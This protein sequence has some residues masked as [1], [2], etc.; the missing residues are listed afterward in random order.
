MYMWWGKVLPGV[1]EF[2]R[3]YI[4]KRL[5]ALMYHIAE[6]GFEMCL[7]MCFDV[8]LGLCLDMC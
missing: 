4:I 1:S 6:L 7:G 8:C 2:D 5:Q 3:T